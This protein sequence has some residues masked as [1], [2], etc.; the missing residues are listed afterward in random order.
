MRIMTLK[1]WKVLAGLC[2]LAMA[3]VWAGPAGA[4]TSEV[5]EKPP[6]YT[7]VAEWNIPRAQ[8][9]EMEKETA[10]TRKWWKRLSRTA[11]L[12]DMETM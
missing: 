12:W 5:K 6:L 11:Q 1:L 10:L 8:W 3:A 9:A 7:Y 4:Q 2:A